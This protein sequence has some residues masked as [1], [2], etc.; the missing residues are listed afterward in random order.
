[1]HLVRPSP[2]SWSDILA[3]IQY[4]LTPLG[5]QTR[6]SDQVDSVSVRARSQYFRRS[7]RT[8]HGLHTRHSEPGKRAPV[9]PLSHCSKYLLALQCKS[10]QKTNSPILNTEIKPQPKLHPHIQ[11]QRQ[12]LMSVFQPAHHYT[13]EQMGEA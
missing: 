12:G 13:C 5:L 7:L 6:G 1:M 4:L 10:T 2:S 3:L 9:G 11:C 8:P